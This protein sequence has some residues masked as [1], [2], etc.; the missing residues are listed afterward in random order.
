MNKKESAF[1][2]WHLQPFKRYC[3]RAAGTGRGVS[4]ESCW[5]LTHAPLFTLRVKNSS[6]CG[7]RLQD[8]GSLVDA[9][10]PGP[11]RRQMDPAFWKAGSSLCLNDKALGFPGK[12]HFLP[13]A[14]PRVCRKPRCKLEG[15]I[16]VAARLQVCGRPR[17]GVLHAGDGCRLLKRWLGF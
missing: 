2:S 12:S 6:G 8:P 13:A 5:F 17:V 10:F 14:R 16:S 4:L 9:S 15:R 11:R 7:Q 3:D 1:F